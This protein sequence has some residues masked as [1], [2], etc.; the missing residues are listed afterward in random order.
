MKTE[1]IAAFED[2]KS[3]KAAAIKAGCPEDGSYLDY[4][5]AHDHRTAKKFATKPEAIAWLQ[6]KINTMETT[7]GCGDITEGEIVPPNLRCNYCT[8]RGWRPIKR[9]TVDDTGEV[10]GCSIEDCA[11]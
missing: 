4:A 8:C 11:D 6:E 10:D 1:F 5:E 7:F 3:L 9:Y 2:F